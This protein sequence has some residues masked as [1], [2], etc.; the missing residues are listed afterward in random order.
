[1]ET[2]IIKK[3]GQSSLF[4]LPHKNSDTALRIHVDYDK[5][6]SDSVEVRVCFRYGKSLAPTR[7]FVVKQDEFIKF[8]QE[9]DGKGL[10]EIYIVCCD[11]KDKQAEEGFSATINYEFN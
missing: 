2:K 5:C 3:L 8:K 9:L 1:M 4:D 6:D 10:R 11:C 7:K